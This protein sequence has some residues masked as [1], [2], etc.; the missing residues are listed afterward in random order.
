MNR[1]EGGRLV[2]VTPL[3][4][5]PTGKAICPKGRAAPELVHS[6]RRLTRP[7]KRTRPKD[8]PDPGFVEIEWDEALG[9]I[10][11]KLAQ[12]AEETGPESVAFSFASPSAASI[13]DNIPWL[14]RFVWRYGSPNILWATEL[15][16]WHKDHMH[17]LTVGSGL[18]VPDYL[19]SDVIVLWGHNPEK[20]WLAQAEKIASALRRGAELVIIDPRKTAMVSQAAQWLRVKPGTDGALALALIRLLI[21]ENLA[22]DAFVRA[23]TNAPFL[24]RNDTR[25]PLLAEDIGLEPAGAFV[26]CDHT[27]QLVTIDTARPPDP[28][29]CDAF[30]LSAELEVR[31]A[32]GTTVRCKTAFAHLHDASE[33]YTPERTAAI[34]QVDADEIVRFGHRLGASRRTSY[35]CWTGVGQHGNATQTDRAI[36]CLFALTGQYDVEGGN[37]NWPAIPVL[38]ISDYSMLPPGQAEKSLGLLDKPLGPSTGGWITGGDLYRAILDK[39]PYRIRALLSFGSNVLSSQPDPTRGLAALRALDLHVHCDLFL[40]PSAMTADI[41]LPVNSAWE[42]DGWRAG[43][44]ISLQAQQRLQLRP[45]MVAPR[46]EARSDFE[47]IAAL[48]QRLGFGSHFHD[49]DWEAAHDAIMAPLGIT[50]DDLRRAPGGIDI[51]LDHAFRSYANIDA[52]GEVEGFATPSRRVELYSPQLAH[53]G[54]AAVPD[55][56][57]P[58]DPGPEHPLVLTTAKNG[59][60]CHTQH[61][62]LNTLRRK[63]PVPRVDIHPDAARDRGIAELSTV[64]I[65]RNGRRISM[66]ARFDDALHPDVVVA[67]YGWWQGAPDIGAPSYEIGGR[68]D[69]NY[70]SLAGFEALD[71]ISGA[72]A[73]RSMCCD[74]RARTDAHGARWSGFRRMRVSDKTTEVEGITV[75][76]LTPTDGAVLAPFSAG[77]FVSIRLPQ[78]GPIGSSR[79]YSLIDAP[80]SAPSSYSIAIRRHEGGALSGLL[81]ELQI[82]DLIEATAPAGHFTLPIDNEFP[83]VLVAAGIGI[84]PFLSLLRQARMGTGPEIHLYYGS[85]NGKQHAFG[86]EIGAI[87]AGSDRIKVHTFYSRP[88]VDELAPFRKGR[89]GVE[90]ID[91]SLIERRARFYMCGPDDMLATMRQGLA[92]RGVPDFE[93]FYE[94]FVAARSSPATMVQPREVHFA[95]QKKT[96]RWHFEDGSL[97]DLAEKHDIALPSGCRTG[98]CE[99]CAIG[100]LAGEFGHFVDVAVDEDNACLGCQAYPL[101]DMVLDI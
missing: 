83:V 8:D 26:A 72:P 81:S 57:A 91:R 51:P 34:C 73:V 13:S 17:K 97:L 85:R 2:A 101:S 41:V 80:R 45:S 48:A 65:V 25:M 1:I 60:F 32:D 43:F 27:G 66:Q 50:V 93:I 79:S 4:E 37:V 42:R 54:Y 44:E 82:G 62:G 38:P 89:L 22:N 30:E 76:T 69:A 5:H 10:A 100:V 24:I 47:I 87:A 3:P 53:H 29:L 16:N 70:N 96:V 94:R 98:Q 28:N 14:E 7:L 40:N 59:Y 95:R 75:L 18:P 88:A 68:N 64:D 11:G 77:Q 52:D 78:P 15:C 20:V 55:F 99:S 56:V 86:D 35:Y 36:A 21:A 12:F 31:L 23:W 33:P 49:G 39:Q 46:G 84:T 92:R 9:H 67:E 61:R 63:S 58:E 19:N 71:P 90:H 74:V 6:A